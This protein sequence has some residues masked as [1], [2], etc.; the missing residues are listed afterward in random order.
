MVEVK[1]CGITSLKDAHMAFEYGADAL[2]FIFYPGSLR[3]VEPRRAREII[4][5]LPSQMV[6]AGVFVNQAPK[7]VKEIA[8]FCNLDLIQL[9]GD[10]STQYCERFQNFFLIKAVSLSC[11]EELKELKAYPVRAILVDSR[12]PGS[13]GGTGVISNWNLAIRVKEICPLILSGGLNPGNIRSALETVRPQAV[14]INSGIELYPGKK[15]PEKMRKII[16]II[17]EF[18]KTA[19]RKNMRR[20]FTSARD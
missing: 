4:Q 13:Y 1:I 6:R 12:R 16:S 17:R 15:D 5:G 10:E 20:I 7:E 18:G 9:H 11:E 14:D 19:E 3:Y 8:R 2:G